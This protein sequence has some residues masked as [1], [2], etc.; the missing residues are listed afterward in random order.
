MWDVNAAPK[1]CIV[2]LYCLYSYLLALL[3][4]DARSLNA[5]TVYCGHNAVVEVWSIV[6][7]AYYLLVG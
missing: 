6:Y 4:Q 2:F 3:M 7:G 5:K 1:V